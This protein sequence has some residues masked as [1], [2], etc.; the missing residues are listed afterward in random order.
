[1]LVPAASSPCRPWEPG[2]TSDGEDS[3][4]AAA[5]L[6]DEGKHILHDDVT[7]ITPDTLSQSL[8]PQAIVDVAISSLSRS[9]L[10]TEH[11]SEHPPR[12]C[13]QHDIV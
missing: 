7:I 12:L 1:M 8:P 5:L 11:T 9:P 6:Q 4:T 13:G 10:D 3:A 2:A